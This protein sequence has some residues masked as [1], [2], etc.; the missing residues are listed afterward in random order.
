MLLRSETALDGSVNHLIN[1]WMVGFWCRQVTLQCE[2]LFS[3]CLA[4]LVKYLR[5]HF[6]H[7][8]RLFCIRLAYE[9]DTAFS[10]N[11]GIRRHPNVIRM[12]LVCKPLLCFHCCVCCW[13]G[14]LE[15]EWENCLPVVELAAFRSTTSGQFGIERCVVLHPV[16][17]SPLV[18]SPLVRPP[19]V[20]PCIV[21]V[22]NKALRRLVLSVNS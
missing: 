3:V 6:G 15:T 1:P 12:H 19:L 5:N 4:E 8:W 22:S 16:V 2:Q 14:C 17:G 9:S 13:W 7:V 10:Q 18:G 21:V 11:F 20:G